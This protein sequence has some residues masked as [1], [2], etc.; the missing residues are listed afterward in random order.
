[1]KHLYTI[2]TDILWLRLYLGLFLVI[3]EMT[4]VSAA[5]VA[6]T[7][8][9]HDFKHATWIINAYI[10]TWSGEDTSLYQSLQGSVLTAP[11]GFL[12]L[13]S[14]YSHTTGRK[15]SLLTAVGFFV[16]FSAGCAAAQT[17]VQL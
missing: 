14:Q 13:W 6:I 9:L 5:L 16:I 11:E 1:M 7:D 12:V 10:L 4:I 8:E 15:S 2:P 3:M 17:A